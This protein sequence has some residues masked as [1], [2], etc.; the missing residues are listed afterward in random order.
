VTESNRFGDR[1]EPVAVPVSRGHGRRA[2]DGEGVESNAR[3][4]A[5][6][7]V[8]LFVLFA[9][10]GFTILAIGRMLTPHVFIGMLLVPPAVLKIGST[11]W[12]FTRYYVGA[13]A[14][15]QKGPPPLLLRTLGPFVVVLSVAVIG[16]GIVLLL[17]PLS[18]RS[19]LLFLHRATFVLWLG[20]MA[21]HVLGHLV[22][23][24][25]LAP[26]DWYW[27]TRRQVRSA[28]WR[29]WALAISLALGLV[30]AL[31]VVPHVGSWFSGGGVNG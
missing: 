22:E 20:A 6:V 25:R 8:V 23:T 19:E 5:G 29:Q 1:D 30:L 7:A 2:R 13:P 11:M 31:V 18:W 4:T 9:A 14:Y 12:R 3:L 21:I 15:R 17:G 24:A 28:G 10:E 26:R 27:R 16:T